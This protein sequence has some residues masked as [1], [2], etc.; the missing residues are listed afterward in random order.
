MITFREILQEEKIQVSPKITD[1]NIAQFIAENILHLQIPDDVQLVNTSY[2]QCYFDDIKSTDAPPLNLFFMKF[3]ADKM[4][5]KMGF[6]DADVHIPFRLR[7]RTAVEYV[8]PKEIYID[9]KKLK[10]IYFETLSYIESYRKI[11][12]PDFSLDEFRN[13]ISF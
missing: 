2:L 12:N 1:K 8:S 7:R 5:L 13:R 4:Q 6:N 10:R 11:G 9:L 3:D